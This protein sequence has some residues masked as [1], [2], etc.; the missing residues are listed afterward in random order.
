MLAIICYDDAAY[1][2]IHITVGTYEKVSKWVGGVWHLP[3]GGESEKHLS[4]TPRRICA[5]ARCFW[6]DKRTNYHGTTTIIIIIIIK[7][8]NGT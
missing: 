3:L 1:E 4:R 5:C 8:N 6:L 2:P 7:N